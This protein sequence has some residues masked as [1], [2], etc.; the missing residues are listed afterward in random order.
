MRLRFSAARPDRTRFALTGLVAAAALALSACTTPMQFP[1]T[2][3][4]QENL[5]ERGVNIVLISP[6]NIAAYRTP[7]GGT[8][9]RGGVNPPPSPATYTYRLGVGDVLRIQVWTN[10][11]RTQT[12]GASAGVDG[13]GTTIDA[14]GTFFY[15]FVGGIQARGRT[16][17][18]V[19]DELTSKLRDFIAQPQVELSVQSF[20]AHQATITGAVGAPGSITLTNVPMRL[21]DVI[22]EAGT[23]DEADLS[24]V[25]IQRRGVA[26]TVN[27]AEFIR[28]GRSGHNPILL[29][30]DLVN[31]PSLEDNKIFVFGETRTSEI[32]LDGKRLSLTEV[33]ANSGGI[34]RVR[35]DARGVFVFRRTPATP[36]GFD[37]YQFNLRSAEVLV[38]T[39]DFTMAP[40]DIVFVTNDPITRWNDT[41][42]KLMS[43]LT[44][45]VRARGVVTTLAE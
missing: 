30:G 42:G 15:P 27:L 19:R 10:P 6:A 40:L 12:V 2:E 5:V 20:R 24:R 26:Y 34:D 32:P 28:S 39:T 45:F 25:Q 7:P 36:N 38:L 33:L 44:G 37:V 14:N 13:S 43:P 16:I 22:N 21:L 4:A 1:V 41:V 29:P 3:E 18:E 9:R 23:G 31:V 8:V 11:E 35:A 17:G